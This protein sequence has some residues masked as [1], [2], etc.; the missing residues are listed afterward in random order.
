MENQKAVELGG[1]PVKKQRLP[2][3]VARLQMKNQKKREEKMV[4]EDLALGRFKRKTSSSARKFGDKRKPE[5]RVLKSTEGFFKNGVLDVKDLLKSSRA[6]SS[7]GRFSDGPRMM[8]RGRKQKSGGGK[9][10]KNG[11]GKGKGKKRH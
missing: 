9:K 6:S 4:A 8:D 2:L 5:S 1:K 7:E 11:K 3:S 10:K